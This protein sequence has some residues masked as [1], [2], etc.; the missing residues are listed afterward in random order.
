MKAL[1]SILALILG[2]TITTAATPQSDGTSR[3]PNILLILADDLGYADLA[4]NGHATD[5]ATPHLDGIA[6]S[7]VRFTDGYASHPY[8]SPSRAGLM[9]GMYQHRFGFEANSGPESHAAANF[10][11]PRHIPTLAEKLKDAGYATGMI[12]K[13]HIGFREGLRPHERGFDHTYV[14]HS[15][16]RSFYPDPHRSSMD[17][18]CPG[19]NRREGVCQPQASIPMAVPIHPDVLAGWL[20]DLL[21]DE[22]HQLANSVGRRVP[23][24]I[25]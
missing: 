25:G 11:L 19:L 4:A 6:A 17:P 20:H 8:C 15:G 22:A 14:F 24:G 2:A 16:A 9:S 5:I 3:S 21:D 12:G 1:L 10:G 13:W 23:H 18:R 7:G